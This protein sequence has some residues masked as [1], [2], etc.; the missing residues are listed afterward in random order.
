MAKE[1]EVKKE[2]PMPDLS[3]QKPEPKEIILNPE[4]EKLG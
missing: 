4:Y 1:K 3:V 2:V